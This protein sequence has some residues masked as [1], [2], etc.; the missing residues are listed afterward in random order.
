MVVHNE[1]SGRCDGMALA[2]AREL[3]A[4]AQEQGLGSSRIV[5]L[6]TAWE[7]YPRIAT[8][9]GLQAQRESVASIMRTETEL[10]SR[11]TQ[12][13]RKAREMSSLLSETNKV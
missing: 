11:A 2:A 3:A 8:A 13:I 12:I 10:L 1:Y 6:M 4:I 9:V 7:I 5:P